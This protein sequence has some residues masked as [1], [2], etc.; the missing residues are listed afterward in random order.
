VKARMS[1][2]AVSRCSATAGSLSVRASTI[3]SN[4]ACVHAGGVGLVVDAVQQGF[5]PTPGTLGGGGHQVR[6]VVGAA[7]LPRRP[8]QGRSQGGDQAGVGVGG[9]QGDPGQAAGGQIAAERQPAG[10]VFG[11]RHVHAEDLP[12]AVGVHPAGDQDV[13]VDHPA[14]LAHLHRQRIRR[15]KRVRALVERPAAEVGDLSVELASHHTDLG[16]AQPGDAELLDQLLHPPSRHP[17]R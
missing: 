12:V 8:G 17:S 4:W 2:R 13:H 9:H 7:A 14:A 6:G 16:L 3:R 11:R 5:H 10:T 15:Q 1:A